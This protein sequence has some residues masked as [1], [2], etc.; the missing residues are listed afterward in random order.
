MKGMGCTAWRGYECSAA[1]FRRKCRQCPAG[2]L[3]GPCGNP[4]R[5]SAFSNTAIAQSRHLNSHKP[6][7]GLPPWPGKSHDGVVPPTQ[8]AAARAASLLSP[9]L[10]KS[11]AALPAEHAVMPGSCTDGLAFSLTG[12]GGLA[13]V[14]PRGRR[15]GRYLLSS[16][17]STPRHRRPHRGTDHHARHCHIGLT[18]CLNHEPPAPAAAG[19]NPRLGRTRRPWPCSSRLN[20]VHPIESRC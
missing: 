3:P 1:A 4:L 19:L 16:G 18:T 6:T 15:R 11:D 12:L 5:I 14:S 13:D 7:Q 9:S 8:P 10:T 20:R 2:P 17:S